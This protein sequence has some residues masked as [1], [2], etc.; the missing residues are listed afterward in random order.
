MI[1]IICTLIY[2]QSI[3]IFG[4]YLDFIDSSTNSKYFITYACSAYFNTI[5]LWVLRICRSH[6]SIC[7]K[8][9]QD[10][11]SYSIC[12]NYFKILWLWLQYDMAGIFDHIIIWQNFCFN[13]H[14]SSHGL[15]TGLGVG[16]AGLSGIACSP[17]Q[18]LVNIENILC[19][20]VCTTCNRTWCN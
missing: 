19:V 4:E 17:W 16:S 9:V 2:P 11:D 1:I 6:L 13:V 18:G 10:Y 5:G 14:F 20:C 3:A 8:A 7:S 15:R 12:I